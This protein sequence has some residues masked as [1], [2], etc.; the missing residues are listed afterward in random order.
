MSRVGI[1]AGESSD[2][3]RAVPRAIKQVFWRILILYVGTCLA[4]PM[5]TCVLMLEGMMFFIGILIP[6]DDKRLL[7][8]SSKT[9]QSPLTIALSD[10]GILPAAHLINGLIVILVISAGNSSLYVSS[11]T[12][13]HM[14]RSGKAP[15]FLGRTN[16]A[17]VPWV[18]LVFSN[19]FVC[20][21]F[22]SLS[23][24]AG[25]LYSALITLSGSTSSHFPHPTHRTNRQRS[26]NVHRLGRHR[27]HAHSLPTSPR[28]AGPRRV[29]PPL[30]RRVVSVR[31]VRRAGG[32][33]L[34][35]LF[36]GVHCVPEPV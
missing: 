33:C 6:Y 17:G 22:L 16:K 26:C 28:G 14:A 32:E 4:N 35:G 25:R 5:V 34:F 7:S 2:P 31:D 29:D 9:A 18:A 15:A 12:I 19:L 24:N 13:L 36:P 23:S 10:A 8:T 20:I 30:P 1:T 3:G 27:T 21:A 11:R